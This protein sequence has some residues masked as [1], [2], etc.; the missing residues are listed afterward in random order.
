VPAAAV[1]SACRP[2]SASALGR[3]VSPAWVANTL[4]DRAPQ[5]AL[6]TAFSELLA[7]KVIIDLADGLQLRRARVMGDHRIELLNFDSRERDRLK[8]DGLFGE[9]IQCCYRMFVP[10]DDTGVSVLAKV[11]GPLS[12]RAHPA[13]GLTAFIRGRRIGTRHPQL[14]SISCPPHPSRARPKRGTAFPSCW[15]P[16]RS[17]S[18][19]AERSTTTAP[20]FRISVGG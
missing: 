13:D 10:T 2:T 9:I 12:D 18:S 5:I 17:N 3:K 19:I 20:L 11:L 14:R 8:A 7:G 4:G 16:S 15:P 6:D 1:S